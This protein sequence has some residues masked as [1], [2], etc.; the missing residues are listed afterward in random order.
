VASWR[1]AKIAICSDFQSFMG[2]GWTIK[3]NTLC[4]LEVDKW[5][6]ALFAGLIVLPRSKSKFAENVPEL[7]Y[8]EIASRQPK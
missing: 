3:L 1:D 5:L 6:N 8:Q 4:L 2:W 7:K